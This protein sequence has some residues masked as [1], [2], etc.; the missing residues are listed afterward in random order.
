MNNR[1]LVSYA[2]KKP[3]GRCSKKKQANIAEELRLSTPYTVREFFLGGIIGMQPPVPHRH[4]RLFS[5]EMKLTY[6]SS[7]QTP[8]NQRRSVIPESKKH[9]DQRPTQVKTQSDK[10]KCK[11]P[12]KKGNST[13]GP[14]KKPGTQTRYRNQIFT[15][16]RRRSKKVQKTLTVTPKISSAFIPYSKIRRHVI[17]TNA[18]HIS[19]DHAHPLSSPLWQPRRELFA[20]CP[21]PSSAPTR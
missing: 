18:G 6:P 1:V 9:A 10:P 15:S 16:H 7:P 19:R 21:R 3:N 8:G 4:R 5:P 11:Q 13:P 20:R 14:A 2:S 17:K 12:K